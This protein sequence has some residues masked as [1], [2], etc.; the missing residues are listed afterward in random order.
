MVK[1]WILQIYSTIAMVPL[2]KSALGILNHGIAIV[3]YSAQH[4]GSKIG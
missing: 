1:Y 3:E 2:D 4:D